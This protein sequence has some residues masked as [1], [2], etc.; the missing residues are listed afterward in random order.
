MTSD[1]L[2]LRRSAYSCQR[3][4]PV[5]A[6]AASSRS[7][8]N[9]H[10]REITPTTIARRQVRKLARQVAA[11]KPYRVAPVVRINNARLFLFR[12]N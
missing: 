9:G 12:F 5:V 2:N 4:I 1:D 8:I 7:G 11:N 10:A 6:E 3:L